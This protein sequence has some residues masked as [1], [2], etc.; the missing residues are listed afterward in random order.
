MG[1]L[2]ISRENEDGEWRSYHSLRHFFIT[3]ASNKVCSPIL[4]QMIV[5]HERQ[6]LGV[7]E[8]YMHMRMDLKEA[9]KVVDSV[10]V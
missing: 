3:S 4:L 1:E 6:K 8:N 7:T 5:G 2:G 9:Q 10:V